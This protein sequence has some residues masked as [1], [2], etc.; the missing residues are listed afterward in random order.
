MVATRQ[1]TFFTV[2]IVT[3]ALEA[4]PVGEDGGAAHDAAALAAIAAG[5]EA[6]GAA[7]AMTGADLQANAGGGPVSGSANANKRPDRS[8]SSAAIV[9]P[10]ARPRGVKMGHAKEFVMGAMGSISS[11]GNGISSFGF[12]RT[13]SSATTSATSAAALLP[14]SVLDMMDANAGANK[15][16]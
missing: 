6:H 13:T 12:G 11:I 3:A 5:F 7:G 2:D 8:P 14:P 1:F 9:P 15:E 16:A 10:A 4:M